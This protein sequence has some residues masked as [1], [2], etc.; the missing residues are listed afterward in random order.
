MPANLGWLVHSLHAYTC[1]V[2]LSLT[3]TSG[4]LLD[5]SAQPAVFAAGNSKLDPLFVLF[6]SLDLGHVPLCA[7]EPMTRLPGKE[8]TEP[9]VCVR[10]AG[11]AFTAGLTSLCCSQQGARHTRSCGTHLSNT[12]ESPRV[13][14]CTSSV[15]SALSGLLPFLY[16]PPRTLRQ[17]RAQVSEVLHGDGPISLRRW[18]GPNPSHKVLSAKLA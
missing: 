15:L 5:P 16:I 7:M 1:S 4:G 3:R 18:P 12:T 9:G 10:G 13:Q 17:P 11:V 2:C 8:R 6:L 14:D